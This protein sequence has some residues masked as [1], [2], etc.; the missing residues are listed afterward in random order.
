MAPYIELAIGRQLSV[1]DRRMLVNREE[2]LTRCRIEHD[3]HR[4]EISDGGYCAKLMEQAVDLMLIKERHNQLWER[5][6]P[7]A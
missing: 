4:P 2:Y 1:D 3:D 5:L 7:D 6:E